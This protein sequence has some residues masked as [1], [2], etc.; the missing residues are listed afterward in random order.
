MEDEKSMLEETRRK[1][2]REGQALPL[3]VRKFRKGFTLVEL[4]V[5]I[6]IIGIL[7]A[8]LIP[9]ML[10]YVANSRIS[11]ANSA[12][13]SAKTSLNSYITEWDTQDYGVDRNA[14]LQSFPVSVDKGGVW[15]GGEVIMKASPDGVFAEDISGEAQ[16]LNEWFHENL[17]TFRDCELVFYTQ[18]GAVLACIYMTKAGSVV[19]MTYDPSTATGNGWTGTHTRKDGMDKNGVIVGTY[20]PCKATPE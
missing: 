13:S 14:P 1:F 18:G 9:T 10:G 5:V 20:P 11:A 3:R 2:R 12:A 17:P 7:A 19:S 15:F 8:I 16:P 6:A 4:I